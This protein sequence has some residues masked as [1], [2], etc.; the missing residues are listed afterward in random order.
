MHEIRANDFAAKKK[1]V[2]QF[3]ALS[4]NPMIADKR[5]AV[6]SGDESER[7]HS[8]LHGQSHEG[9][10]AR[11]L[12][13]MLMHIFFVTNVLFVFGCACGLQERPCKLEREQYTS[14]C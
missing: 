11:S 3:L 9:F 13:P 6:V 8:C 10:Q 1:V 7:A 2:V 5:A 14:E 12:L 4:L